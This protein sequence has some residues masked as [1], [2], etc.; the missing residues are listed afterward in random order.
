MQFRT[1]IIA[2][3]A[4]AV[5]SAANE[6]ANAT[7]TTTSPSGAVAGLSG[8][9]VAGVAAAAAADMRADVSDINKAIFILYIFSSQEELALKRFEVNK[10]IFTVEKVLGSCK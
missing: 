9:N 10:T 5:V 2:L 1:V 3:T 4:A 6:T 8:I 7:N